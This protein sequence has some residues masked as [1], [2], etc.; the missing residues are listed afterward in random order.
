MDYQAVIEFELYLD[1]EDI[2]VGEKLTIKPHIMGLKAE[3]LMISSSIKKPANGNVNYQVLLQRA[4]Q[5]SGS[6]IEFLR[7]ELPYAWRDAYADMTTHPL[8]LVRFTYGSFEYIFDDYASLEATSVAPCCADI[9]ARL[10]VVLGCSSPSSLPRDDYRLKG[11]IG[12]TGK[13]FGNR[14]DK[15][16]YIAHTIGGAVDGLEANVFVQRRDLNRG[17][18][19]EGKR[20]REMEKYCSMNKGTFCFSRPLYIDQSSKP[21]FIEFGI[22]KDGR[23]LC[24]ELFD[25]S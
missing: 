6:L 20:Y 21:A 24:V 4:L 19:T 7:D 13:V 5:H 1:S 10:M 12:A 9:E 17:W 11:W 23:E 2:Q 16:H 18:S 25:N 22:L 15:G 14:W 8:N 3:S